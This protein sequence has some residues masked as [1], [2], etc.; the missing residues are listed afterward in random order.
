MNSVLGGPLTS[1]SINSINWYIQA[2]LGIDL[3]MFTF[4]VRYQGG[5]ND[6][7]SSVEQG[8]QTWNFDSRNNVFQLS[9]G[10]KIL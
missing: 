1:S 7:I 4:D 6:V 5:L 9:L 3:W 10:F 2:G 8:K